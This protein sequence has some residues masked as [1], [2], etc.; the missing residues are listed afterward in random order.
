MV[1]RIWDLHLRLVLDAALL[2]G[3]PDLQNNLMFR[4]L[5]PVPGILMDPRTPDSRA[6]SVSRNGPRLNDLLY[7]L[8]PRSVTLNPA[9]VLSKLIGDLSLVT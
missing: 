5:S 1:D 4:L 9:M 6:L 7:D 3:C 2:F 8:M